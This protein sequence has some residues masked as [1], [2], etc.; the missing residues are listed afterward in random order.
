[1]LSFQVR[2]LWVKLNTSAGCGGN[3]PGPPTFGE[4]SPLA[5]RAAQP[6]LEAI[7]KIRAAVGKPKRSFEPKKLDQSIKDRISALV[8]KQI[9]ESSLITDKAKRYGLA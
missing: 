5:H 9:I 8:D 7:E 2:L 6:I 4:N 3:T 1:M